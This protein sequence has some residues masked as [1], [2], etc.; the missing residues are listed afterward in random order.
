MT[1]RLTENRLPNCGGDKLVKKLL[2][3]L[4]QIARYSPQ[5]QKFLSSISR[6]VH[7]SQTASWR[8][9]ITNKKNTVEAILMFKFSYQKSNPDPPEK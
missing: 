9:F 1:T 6:Y 7:D 2:L 3:L 5:N 4:R 8:S